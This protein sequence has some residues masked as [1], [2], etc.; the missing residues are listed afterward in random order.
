MSHQAILSAVQERRYAKNNGMFPEFKYNVAGRQVRAATPMKKHY[1]DS[2]EDTAAKYKPGCNKECFCCSSIGISRLVSTEEFPLWETELGI[3]NMIHEKRCHSRLNH[4]RQFSGLYKRKLD[5]KIPQVDDPRLAL[6]PS[7]ITAPLRNQQSNLR[8]VHAWSGSLR[9][10]RRCQTASVTTR[11][12]K[13]MQSHAAQ[14]V[15]VSN[16]RPAHRHRWCCHPL[17]AERTNDG[18][19]LGLGLYDCQYWDG[20]A[21]GASSKN[22]TEQDNATVVTWT[23]DYR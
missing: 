6:L 19:N 1:G 4:R 2:F 11:K 10:G 12:C 8:T 7:Q 22:I 18:H 20:G 21:D 17:S 5:T 14:G 9:T 15:F 23:L 13:K 16:K 3:D